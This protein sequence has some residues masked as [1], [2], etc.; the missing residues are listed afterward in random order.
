MYVL[1]YI[2]TIFIPLKQNWMKEEEIH[3]EIKDAIPAF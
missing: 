1:L 3:I 2:L